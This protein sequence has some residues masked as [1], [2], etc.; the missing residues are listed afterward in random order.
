MRWLKFIVLK[1]LLR[2]LPFDYVEDAFYR[3]VILEKDQPRQAEMWYM[4]YKLWYRHPMNV[5][6]KDLK[7]RIYGT[8]ETKETGR[9]T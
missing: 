7:K 2:T 3:A 5:H 1:W 8:T 6:L 9:L 4:V